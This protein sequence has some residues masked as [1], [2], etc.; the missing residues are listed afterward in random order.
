MDSKTESTTS[1]KKKLFIIIPILVVLAVVIIVVCYR[2]LKNREA[3]V[4][5]EHLDDAAATINGE[6]LLYR[7]LS[8]YVL[9][10]EQKVEKEA[11]VYNPES[12]KDW[13]NSYV[14]G[15]FV[16]VSAAETALN[17]AIHDHIMYNLAKQE[18]ITLSEE[19]KAHIEFRRS[20]F[21]EDLYDEQR[22]RLP[23][24]KE[25]INATIDKIGIAEKYQRKLAADM[26]VNDFEYNF[27]GYEYKKMLEAN[28][29]VEIDKQYEK[30]VFGEITIHHSKV[31]FINGLTSESKK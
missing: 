11:R 6:A 29:K 2:G 19:E 17:M 10:I 15:K 5:S 25:E 28:Y 13:W 31:N 3:F 16:S 18:G 30:L 12:P 8:F 1:S 20:D 9:Y 27:D 23:V 24:S 26:G 21:W 14:N 4:F 22:E 7:E